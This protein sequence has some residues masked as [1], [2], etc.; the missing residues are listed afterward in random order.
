M[1]CFT[2]VLFSPRAWSQVEQKL[3]SRRNRTRGCDSFGP[4]VRTMSLFGSLIRKIDYNARSTPRSRLL[5]FSARHRVTAVQTPQLST[6]YYIDSVKSAS[7]RI[8]LFITLNFG[9]FPDKA[10]LF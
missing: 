3:I 10:L 7:R 2:E 6:L 4:D 1:Q 9:C 5:F 8:F